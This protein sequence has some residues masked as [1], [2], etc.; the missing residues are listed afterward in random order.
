MTDGTYEKSRRAWD[1]YATI[2]APHLPKDPMGEVQVQLYRWQVNNFDLQPAGRF[3]LGIVEELGELGEAVEAEDRDAILDAVADVC[4]YATQLATAHRLDFG[5]LIAAGRE[6][7]AS[8]SVDVSVGRMAHAVL[9]TEQR[10]RGYD[11]PEKGRFEVAQALVQ[12][13]CRLDRMT[14]AMGA[15]LTETYVSTAAHVLA[16][17]WKA[18]PLTAGGRA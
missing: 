3:V 8:T 5:V 7:S 1:A 17:D 15:D 14:G 10:I 6:L 16:R 12:L 2:D 4:I 18:D 9:K 13:V 11:D